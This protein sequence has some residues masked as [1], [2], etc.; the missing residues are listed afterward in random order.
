MPSAFTPYP[1]DRWLSHAELVAWCEH[2]AAALPDH[3][4]LA[5]VGHA[6]D[7]SP[8]LLVTLGERTSGHP[9]DRPT[10]WLDAGTHAAEWAGVAAALGSL[11]VWAEGLLA[12]DPALTEAFRRHTVVCMPCLCPDGYQAMLDGQP[13]LRSTLRPPPDGTV[14]SGWEPCDVD[15]DGVVRWLRFLHPAGTWV[16]DEAPDAPPGWLRP[17]TLDDP[18]ERAWY[19]AQEGA[20]LDWDGVRLTRAPLRH[21]LDLNRN[22]PGAWSPFRMFG[23]DGGAFPGSE[24]ESRAVLDA[25][26][27]RPTVA[28]ALTHHTWTGCL[29]TQPYRKDSPVPKADQELMELLARD[30]VRGT[31]YDVYRTFPDFTYDPERPIVGVWADTLCTVFGVPAYTLELWSPTREA[32]LGSV[33]PVSMFLKPDPVVLRQLASHFAREPGAWRPWTAFEHPQLGPVE[34][35]GLD[36]QRTVRNPPLRL[37]AAECAR[38]HAVADRMRRALPDVHATLASRP[39]GPSVHR[40]ELVLENR[41]FLGTGGLGAAERDGLVGP[42]EV[43]LEGVAP[44]TGQR[45]TPL[46]HLIGWGQ[47]RLDGGMN[48]LHADL[49]ARSQRQVLTWTVADPDAAVV[50]WNA[51]RGGRGEVRLQR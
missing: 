29:L 37:L 8:L 40:L 45:V 51:W 4:Q 25:V 13:Y 10:L 26:R 27:S 49:P 2:L 31:T 42:I 16:E 36:R 22:F 38:A 20:F 19:L 24:P 12:G 21:G 14:R 50:R 39:L 43:V 34:L 44:L 30:A 46:P 3:V 11:S 41:G 47:A 35:G 33:E 48:A 28:A 5:T 23:M 32:G 6:A 9:A 1:A 15:G 18:P 17:R 7:G